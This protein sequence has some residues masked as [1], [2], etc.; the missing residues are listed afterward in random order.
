MALC[1]AMRGNQTARRRANDASAATPASIISQVPGSGTTAP[2]MANVNS[3]P[4]WSPESAKRAEAV[5]DKLC[6]A[7]PTAPPEVGGCPGA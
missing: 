4:N 1:A 3:T 2:W 6:T 7:L 5:A